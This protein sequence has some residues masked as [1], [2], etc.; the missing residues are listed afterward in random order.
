MDLEAAHERN[1]RADKLTRL[2]M[3]VCFLISGGVLLATLAQA[4][5]ERLPAALTSSPSR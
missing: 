1:T 3:I 4:A 2:C 5:P